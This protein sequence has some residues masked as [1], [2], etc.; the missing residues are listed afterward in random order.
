MSD[1][2]VEEYNADLGPLARHLKA[3]IPD[4]MAGNSKFLVIS[5]SEIFIYMFS[6]KVFGFQGGEALYVVYK[7][8]PFLFALRVPFVINSF[9]VFLVFHVYWAF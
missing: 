5:F 4:K 6:F 3:T 7:G 9:L 8:S 1:E 2:E